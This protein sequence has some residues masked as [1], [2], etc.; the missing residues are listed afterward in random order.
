MITGIRLIRIGGRD[1]SQIV[2]DVN[3]HEANDVVYEGGPDEEGAHA[4]LG[5]VD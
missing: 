1:V 2:D 3:K 5:E 4:C